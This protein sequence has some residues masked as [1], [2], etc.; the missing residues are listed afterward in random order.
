MWSTLKEWS[1]TPTRRIIWEIMQDNDA[2]L[3][4]Y[5][6]AL[7]GPDTE[8]GEK[9]WLLKTMF[10]CYIRGK[11]KRVDDVRDFIDCV[12]T[13][14]S[15]PSLLVN[16]AEEGVN[17]H[18]LTHILSALNALRRFHIGDLLSLTCSLMLLAQSIKDKETKE[19]LL[20]YEEIH[21]KVMAEIIWINLERIEKEVKL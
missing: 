10:T 17:Y 21:K 14:S 20:F 4:D 7:R 2:D 18:Y 19:V 1:E 8:E 15:F 5:V 3:W 16:L 13:F 12:S 6:T 9:K 11:H